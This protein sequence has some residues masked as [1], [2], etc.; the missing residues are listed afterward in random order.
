[1]NREP[2]ISIVILNWNQ[3]KLTL[4]CLE[5][6]EN[7]H[8]KNYDVLV[9]DNGSTD[10]SF[11]MLKE[12]TARHDKITILHNDQN[13]GF[14]GGMNIGI[15]YVLQTNHP[16]YVFLLNNDAL[17][18]V[19]CLPGSVEAAQNERADIV[20]ALVKSMDGKTILFAGGEPEKEF[21]MGEVTEQKD[22]LPDIWLTGRVEG[23][24]MLIASSFL[25]EVF[26]TYGYI[27]HPDLFLYGEDVDIAMIA[28]KHTKK[29]VMARN[30]VIYHQPGQ[31]GGGVSNPLQYYYS[32]RNRIFLANR[33]LPFWKRVLF[34]CYY[35]PTRLA[36]IMQRV[37][38]GK[39]E[40][41]S[42]IIHSLVDGYS[43]R[44][45]KWKKHKN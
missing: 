18:D 13:E 16:E 5:S 2:H 19:E 37:F 4:R 30:A 39:W 22:M 10:D 40:V 12:C 6:L 33:W 20:G 14:A 21:F 23:S 34:H 26:Q 24:G 44:F 35:V 11:T 9:L 1:M 36:R 38:Q 17:I 25:R 3:G 41:A 27:F 31:S 45:G 29:I 8:Y 28:R 7:V 42:A 15:D 32:S 43:G